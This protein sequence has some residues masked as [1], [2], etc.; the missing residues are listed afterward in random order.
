MENKEPTNTATTIEV[1]NA[2]ND[3]GRSPL[4][5]NLILDLIDILV[6]I[7]IFLLA[8][9]F[10]FGGAA[11]GSMSGGIDTALFFFIRI[12]TPLLFLDWLVR[13]YLKRI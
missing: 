11:S 7:S 1:P 5:H 13:L 3:T 10:I 2:N 9:G 6:V 4:K 8:T 12:T